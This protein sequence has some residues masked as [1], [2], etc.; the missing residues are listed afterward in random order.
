ML[1]GF[2]EEGIGDAEDDSRRRLSS[3]GVFPKL[4]VVDREER[5]VILKKMG[6]SFQLES[7]LCL[8][9]N[10]ILYQFC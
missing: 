2:G 8:S 7:G 4:G 10:F 5:T 1:K 9:V 6:Q 3:C